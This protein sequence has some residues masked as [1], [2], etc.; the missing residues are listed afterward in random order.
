VITE[1]PLSSTEILVKFSQNFTPEE[2][3]QFSNKIVPTPY[4]AVIIDLSDV[5]HL[6]YAALGKLYMLKLE[7]TTRS[8][9]LTFQGVSEKLFNML[10]LLKFDKTVEILRFSSSQIQRDNIR[11]EKDETS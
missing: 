7:L 5:N 8:K 6:N 3:Q 10:K 2:I 4:K 9:R 11:S 1:E